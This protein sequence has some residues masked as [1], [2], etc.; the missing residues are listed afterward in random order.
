MGD[1]AVGEGK[2]ALESGRRFACPPQEGRASR[3]RKP[4]L[5]KIQIQKS[6]NLGGGFGWVVYKGRVQ[7][8]PQTHSPR[9]LSIHSSHMPIQ[10]LSTHTKSLFLDHQNF[11][12]ISTCAT[13][14]GR[15]VSL[16]KSALSQKLTCIYLSCMPIDEHQTPEIRQSLTKVNG[17]SRLCVLIDPVISFPFW[18]WS[19]CRNKVLPKE[20]STI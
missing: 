9:N 19:I 10:V 17:E 20:G 8:P 15:K 12:H 18:L 13:N 16:H 5:Q 14:I 3:P 1:L 6:R 4:A 7:Q 11:K 2:E